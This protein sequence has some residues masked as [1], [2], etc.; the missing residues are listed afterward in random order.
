MN[1]ILSC[2]YSFTVTIKKMRLG[3]LKNIQKPWCTVIMGN[4]IIVFKGL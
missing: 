1:Q 2:F 3:K 4:S